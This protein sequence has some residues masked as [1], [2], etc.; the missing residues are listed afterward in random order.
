MQI[1]LEFT[2]HGIGKLLVPLFV[3]LVAELHGNRHGARRRL[4]SHASR[5]TPMG[6]GC[7]IDSGRLTKGHG[8]ALLTEPDHDRRRQLSHRAVVDGWSVRNLDA[9]IARGAASRRA[10]AAPHPT[11]SQQRLVSRTPSAER[12]ESPSRRAR[13]ETDISC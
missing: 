4:R 7:L 9:E 12:W 5:D 13:T 8:E 6:A 11:T 2:G 1:D 3:R 10:R